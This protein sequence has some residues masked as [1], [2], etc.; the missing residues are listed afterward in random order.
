MKKKTKSE[1]VKKYHNIDETQNK[2]FF[3]EDGIASYG[4]LNLQKFKDIEALI[5]FFLSIFS[6]KDSQNM[7]KEKF[8]SQ[9]RRF[10]KKYLFITVYKIIWLTVRNILSL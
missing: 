5:S 1:D 7:D 2:T 10:R 4:S 6:E 3:C 9:L 8:L